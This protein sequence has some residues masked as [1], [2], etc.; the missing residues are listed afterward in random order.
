MKER[1]HNSLEQRDPVIGIPVPT[2]R[3]RAGLTKPAVG[4]Q[5]VRRRIY[6]KGKSEKTWRFWGLYRHI[7][8][9][10]TLREA[11]RLAKGNNGEPGVDGV[12]FKQIEEEGREDF[13]RGIRDELA[14]EEY[15]PLKYREVEIPKGKG[16]VR[17][18]RIPAIRDRVVQA[19]LKLILE[20]IFEVDFHNN[21]YGYRPG[22]CAHQMIN[23][24]SRKIV[25]GHRKVLDVDLK[26]YFD[27]IRH[28]ILF[29]K[30][31]ERVDDARVMRLI[32]TI[33][34]TNGR[35]GVPQ[36]GVL[37][38][39]LANIYLNEID[40]LFEKAAVRAR[41]NGHGM[42]DY[43]R[44]A[45][46]MV[47][48][49]DDHPGSDSLLEYSRQKLEEELKRLGVELNGEKTKIVD[50]AKGET[51]NLLGF[52]WRL[53]TSKRGKKYPLITPRAEKRKAILRKVGLAIKEN[54]N[55]KLPVVIGRINPVLRGWVNYFRIGHSSKTFSYV[56]W[57]VEKKIR[58]FVRKKQGRS[59]Y[60]YKKWSKEVPYRDWSLFNDYQIRY[61]LKAS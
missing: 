55:E 6:L 29:K 27:N 50:L 14:R 40:G 13:L 47:V 31:A 17:R 59:G 26:A 33:V 5:E 28:H 21:S 60:G 8:K 39:L 42:M 9:M 23:R 12:T 32:K 18:L 10:E 49:T 43:C 58:R 52:T 4:L 54:W 3:G 1:Q 20:P 51:F 34:K 45:D 38:P 16:K 7:C 2:F 56:R 15:H 53:A 46:D 61:Y 19:A 37:S 57:D 25:Y 30:V 36:G 44:F 22:R 48:T 11:Y 35:R 24:V 41:R